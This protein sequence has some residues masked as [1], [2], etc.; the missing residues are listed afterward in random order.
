ML[1]E[2]FLQIAG[3]TSNQSLLITPL[4]SPL[5]SY[6]ILN[7]LLTRGVNSAT[8]RE[9]KHFT[10]KAEHPCKRIQLNVDPES[11]KTVNLLEERP[12]CIWPGNTHENQESKTT[13]QHD[14]N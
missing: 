6:L 12:I 11:N 1:Q 9:A 4:T 14:I 8:P 7:F 5:S 2:Y 10:S 13:Y 3:L